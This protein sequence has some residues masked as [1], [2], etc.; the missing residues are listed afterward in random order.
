MINILYFY[1]HQS[2]RVQVKGK[3]I[4]EVV[5]EDGWRLLATDSDSD[6]AGWLQA[7]QQAI[8]KQREPIRPES[9]QA[10]SLQQGKHS[11]PPGCLR[12][13]VHSN[14]QVYM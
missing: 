7:L 13:Y 10:H 2:T 3:Y 11:E 5:M 6:C 8:K 1:I 4:L 14:N 12:N 9:A